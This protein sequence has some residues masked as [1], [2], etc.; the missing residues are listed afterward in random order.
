M[1]A[2]R[3]RRVRFK[4]GEFF[5]E[6]FFFSERFFAFFEKKKGGTLT[7]RTQQQQRE[8]KKKKCTTR[9]RINS[10]LVRTNNITTDYEVH[11][12]TYPL[13]CNNL[14][15][16]ILERPIVK[17][18]ILGDRASLLRLFNMSML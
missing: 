1:S 5:P 15:N 17:P 12:L 13:R 7:T 16:I 14:T 4:I 10:F 18:D 3:A 6:F 8:R 9:S 2:K 11:T